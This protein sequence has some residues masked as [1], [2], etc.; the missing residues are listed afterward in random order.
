MNGGLGLLRAY[1]AR[2]WAG[3]IA[4]A[5]LCTRVWMAW[6]CY[7]SASDSS[8][9][10]SISGGSG[11]SWKEGRSL[12]VYFSPVNVKAPESRMNSARA[13]IPLG[14]PSSSGSARSRLCLRSFFRCSS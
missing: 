5:G 10:E 4:L 13:A 2:A 14:V 12:G 3:A 11:S 8:S 6:A 9:S 1:D 7:G